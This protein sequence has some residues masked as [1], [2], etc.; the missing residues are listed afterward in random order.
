[1]TIN[2]GCGKPSGDRPFTKTDLTSY[3]KKAA[4]LPQNRRNRG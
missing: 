4:L 3:Q 1:M 2:L